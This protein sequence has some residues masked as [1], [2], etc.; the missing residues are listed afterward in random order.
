MAGDAP[1][2]E[3]AAFR[4]S[5]LSEKPFSRRVAGIRICPAALFG[6]CQV[7]RNLSRGSLYMAN[8][9]DLAGEQ[10]VISP[11]PLPELIDGIQAGV[12]VIDRERRFLFVNRWF[13]EYLDTPVDALIGRRLDRVLAPDSRLQ[14]QDEL[15]A[16]FEQG[17]W[18][19]W[20]AHLL[21]GRGKELIADFDACPLVRDGEIVAAQVT[22]RDI[23]PYHGLLDECARYREA[24]ECRGDEIEALHCIGSA[25]SLT[26]DID[27]IVSLVYD[28]IRRL[29]S[30][31]TFALVIYES[32]SRQLVPK[33]VYHNGASISVKPWFY[34]QEQGL[35]GWTIRNAR[36]LL[37]RDCADEGDRWPIAQDRLFQPGTQSWLSLPLI[38][39]GE[40]VG[41]LCL[42]CQQA[43]AFDDE[44]LNSLQALADQT[45]VVIENVRLHQQAENQ[46]DELQQ[47]NR[48][49]QALQDLSGLLQSSLELRSV[50]QVIVNG[51]VNDLGYEIAMLSVVDHKRDVLSIRAVA[52][53][54]DEHLPAHIYLTTALNGASIPLDGPTL[55]A[56]TVSQGRIVTLHS[57]RELFEA[58][59]QIDVFETFGELLRIETVVIVP[60]LARGKLVGSMFAGG[61]H[62]EIVGRSISLLSAFANQSAIALENAQLYSTVNQRLTEVSTLYA[63]ANQVSYSLNLDVVLDA[64]VITLRRALNCRS[65]VIFLYNEETEYLEIRASDG[66]KPRWQRDAR[67]R[68]GEGITGIV[69]QEAR[70]L[71]IPDTYS[72]ENFIVFDPSVRSLFVVP[73]M[74]K[75]RVIGTL[76]VDD[77]KVD[78]FSEDEGRML[79]IAAAQAAVAIDNARLYEDIKERAEKLEQAYQ[80]LEEASRLKSEFVQN[81]SHELRTPLTFIKAYVDLL[82][83]GTLGPLNN[84]QREKFQIVSDRT[85]A[86]NRLISDIFSLQRLEREKLNLASLQLTQVARSCITGAAETARRGELEL[87]EDFEVDLPPVL[88]DR[89]RLNQVFDNL[90]HNA[91]KFSP[92]GGEIR[93]RL[94]QTG[95]FVRVD[96]ID[97]GIGIPQDKL[98]KI[99]ERFYQVDGTSKRRFSGTG[100][101]LAIVKEIVEAHGGTIDVQSVIDEG[102]TFSFI[103]PVADGGTGH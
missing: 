93:I 30:F 15:G 85:D 62:S 67:M 82:L 25:G 97:P 13:C 64:I 29:F 41:I 16:L 12:L 87:V 6:G 36:P 55:I 98:D 78:A 60:L 22:C 34:D 47:A 8:R 5:S 3:E 86:I 49:M 69:A 18:G 72:D 28:Q 40:V 102:S 90:I 11:I 26:L 61:R 84:M 17:L 48:E 74:V 53:T 45:T 33:L 42:Q 1:E 56:Q 77:T 100:L 96:V 19:D 37:I 91:I 101:G 14:V 95:K 20:Q 7:A 70:S 71:Y 4:V 73:L 32:E 43:A 88:G 52:T 81:V 76:S 50:Y 31:S 27:Q 83:A 58:L 59:G 79:S 80:E 63:L 54:L 75:G 35:I 66:V 94:R 44:D 92:D 39:Q 65:S 46:L 68:L 89:L 38:I 24:L 9:T 10:I 21:T 57:L 103:V 23:T 99:F 2:E 51:L